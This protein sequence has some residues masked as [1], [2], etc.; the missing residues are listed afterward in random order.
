MPASV[1]RW[2]RRKR[3]S[4]T[5]GVPHRLGGWRGELARLERKRKRANAARPGGRLRGSCSDG[6]SSGNVAPHRGLSV[7]KEVR[8]LLFLLHFPDRRLVCQD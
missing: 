1:R 7:D 6:C 4:S 8:V 2:R 5:R 3:P